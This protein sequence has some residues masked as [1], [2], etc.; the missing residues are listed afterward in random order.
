MLKAV[1]FDL[2]GLLVD[3]T[4]LHL[5][6]NQIF[7][8]SFGKLYLRPE[9]GRE[10]M[11][12]V[13][14]VRDYKD[15]FDLPGTVEDLHEKRQVIFYELVKKELQLFPGVFELLE[16]VK[17]RDLKMA[18]ATSGD[19]E[20]VNIIFEKWPRFKYFFTTL[21]VSEDVKRGKP[22]PDVYKK[23]LEKLNIQSME[24][25][26]LEDSFNGVA[27]AKAAG[28]QV[29]AVP[30]KHYPEADFTLADK[31]FGSLNEVVEAINLI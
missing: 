1:I 20:Y 18:L 26:V 13:D 3:S 11:R 10:G 14:I 4:P 6:A 24:A 8:E 22:Y 21:V 2:D 23:A 16:K 17:K 9:S 12:I 31:S 19:R 15:L 28:I 25:V 29:I 27:A 5:E 7:I 30:N